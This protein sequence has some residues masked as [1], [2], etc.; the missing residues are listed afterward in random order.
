MSTFSTN[1]A[2]SLQIF[3]ASKKKEQAIWCVCIIIMIK[4]EIEANPYANFN[5]NNYEN[6][7]KLKIYYNQKFSN[8]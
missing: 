5:W 3:D 2:G 6:E 8:F 1:G 7:I 4:N